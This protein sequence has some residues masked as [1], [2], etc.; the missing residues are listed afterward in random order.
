[1]VKRQWVMLIESRKKHIRQGRM[2][3]KR[4]VEEA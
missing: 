3:V 1:M 2:R 4:F